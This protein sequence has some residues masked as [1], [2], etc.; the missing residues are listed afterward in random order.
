M[1]TGALESRNPILCLVKGM[2]NMLVD[3]K[4]R[5]TLARAGSWTR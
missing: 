2:L 5:R 1:P 3:K 4:P